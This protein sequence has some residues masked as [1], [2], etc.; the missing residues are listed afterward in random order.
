VNGAVLLLV[1]V[2]VGAAIGA[3]VVLWATRRSLA[4]PVADPPVPVAGAET[5]QP[6]EPLHPVATAEDARGVTA[7]LDA[8]DKVLSELEKRYRGRKAGRD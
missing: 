8:S 4:A 5:V 6:V 2:V 1:G 3:G 7:A